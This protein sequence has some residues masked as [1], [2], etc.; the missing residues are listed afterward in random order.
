MKI[1]IIDDD[2]SVL[3]A[4]GRL[5]RAWGHE[6]EVYPSARDFL[7]AGDFEGCLIL[8]IRMPVM[9]GFGLLDALRTL[10]LNPPVIL[11]TAFD[12]PGEQEQAEGYG[13]VAF[14]LKPIKDTVL[15][16]SLEKAQRA[17]IT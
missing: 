10:G 14:L 11:M 4:L 16:E 2:A 9:D 15:K 13:A 12:N 3:R 7:S 5:V 17:L 8:D 6:V 1:H